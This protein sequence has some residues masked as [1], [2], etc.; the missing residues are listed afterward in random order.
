MRNTCSVDT[1]PKVASCNLALSTVFATDNSSLPITIPY[2]A[3]RAQFLQAPSERSWS[4]QF[5]GLSTQQII[6]ETL[7]LYP[8][9]ARI[10]TQED[11]GST[12]EV[13]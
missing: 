11:D 10:F 5:R 6:A 7:R 3:R 12:C 8:S 4:F 2:T 1:F 9:T 13:Q